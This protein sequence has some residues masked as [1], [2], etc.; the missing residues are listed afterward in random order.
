MRH[1]NEGPKADKWGEESDE[2]S[3]TW[4][5]C[6]KCGTSAAGKPAADLGRPAGPNGDPLDIVSEGESDI[7]YGDPDDNGGIEFECDLCQCTLTS[8]DA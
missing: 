4:D 3:A 2:G 8:Q 6:L 7:D 5:L 1:Y